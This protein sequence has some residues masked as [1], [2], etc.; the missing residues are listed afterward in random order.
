MRILN[1]DELSPSMEQD[2][3]LSNIAAFGGVLSPQRIEVIRRNLKLFSD[4]V[5]VFAVEG[6]RLLG[7]VYVLRI[8]YT[9]RDGP[10]LISGIAS[11]G[12]RPDVGRSGVARA[13]LTEAHRRECAAGLRFAALW[14]NRSWGAHN[15]YETLGYRDVYSSPW[16]V[17]SPRHPRTLKRPVPGLRFA[18]PSDLDEIDKLHDQVATGRLGYCRRPFGFTRASVQMGNIDPE[19]NLLVYRKGGR[20]LG[21]AHLDR[22]S[23]RVICSEL[24][25]ESA[26]ASKSLIAGLNRVTRGTPLSFQHTF[27]SDHPELFRDAAFASIPIGWYVMMGASFARSWTQDEAIRQFATNDPRFLCLGGDRF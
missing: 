19:K 3:T 10:E 21:Y 6:D 25:A 1:Y 15:L 7:H 26:G 12:T 16:V 14:T 17:R 18:R 22:N 9:F 4:Y 11:V 5:G 23:N 2:R 27:V 13:L 24:V 20:L 8:P